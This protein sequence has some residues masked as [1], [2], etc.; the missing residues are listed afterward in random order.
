MTRQTAIERLFHTWLIGAV[1]LGLIV[2]A[3]TIAGKYGEDQSLA[4]SW[5]LS[6]MTAPCSL[7]TVAAFVDPKS[8]WRK[9]DANQFKFR[10]AL[11]TSVL[12]LLIAFGTLLAEPLVSMSWYDLFA[13]TGIFV[14]FL[15]A[16]V[17]AAVGAV[18][19]DQ[20]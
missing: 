4:W 3:Q 1:I 12:L 2:L 7:L 15:Q 8:A 19:F 20:R 14:A 9:A 10:A 17:T 18:V 16:L 5:Y 6:V 11:W 13:Q